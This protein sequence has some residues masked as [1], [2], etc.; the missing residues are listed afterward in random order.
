M[1]DRNL[2]CCF[3]VARG[4][5][6]PILTVSG[7]LTYPAGTSC[8]SRE[9]TVLEAENGGA[10]TAEVAVTLTLRA[11]SYDALTADSVASIPFRWAARQRID[12][13]SSRPACTT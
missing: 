9:E 1:V 10:L 5:R 13:G 12:L 8:D 11:R 4:A 7:Y 3:C 2:R 6:L